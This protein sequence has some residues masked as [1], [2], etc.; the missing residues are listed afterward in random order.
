MGF[1]LALT[2][3]RPRAE[4]LDRLA[5]P[6]STRHDRRPVLIA[7]GG[8]GG[9]LFPAEALAVAL[10][11]ARRARSSSRRTGAS[12]RSPGRFPAERVVADPVRHAVRRLARR[13]RPSRPLKLG[14][15]VLAALRLV[16][17]RR[18]RPASSASAAT[19]PCRRSSRPPTLQ[20]PTL[21]HEQNGVIGRANRFL[22]GRVSR[23]RDR[24]P[25]RR[26][27][28]RTRWPARRYHTGNPIRPAVIGGRR[29]PP[30]RR[31]CPAARS[32]SLVFGGSQGARV[33]SEIVPAALA[34]SAA[35]D[36]RARLARRPAGARRR[37]CG[38]RPR[39]PMRRPASRPIVA[40]LLHRPAGPHGGARISSSRARAPR[41]S[42]NSPPSAARRSSCRCPG[43]LDQ[44]QA[45]NARS[46][47]GDRRRDRDPPARLHAGAP[48]GRDRRTSR[49]SRRPRRRGGRRRRAPA[50]STRPSGSPPS[51]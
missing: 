3:R 47:D 12:A 9:H 17:A 28:S 7:A 5:V 4:M 49:R 38:R 32:G 35:A 27:A 51:S 46:L 1:L 48:G 41:R 19:R 21:I 29:R 24:L 39:R 33:M 45:A 16:R 31:R 15:G 22:L 43:A 50:C 6:A 30:S 23:H 18:G 25:D 13:R 10:R 11:Q 20:V 37:T 8:T 44:D 40:A 36:A 34:L 14:R 2:R 42:R 26:A